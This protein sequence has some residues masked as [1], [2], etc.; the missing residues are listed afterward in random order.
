MDIKLSLGGINT[1]VHNKK[2][3]GG[4]YKAEM[5][6]PIKMNTQSL[7]NDLCEQEVELKTTFKHVKEEKVVKVFINENY[8]SDILKS[9]YSAISRIIDNHVYHVENTIEINKSGNYKVIPSIF[10]E[11]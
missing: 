7:L 9:K 1:D 3:H 8:I 10:F 11:I 6:S 4:R 2:W 5:I